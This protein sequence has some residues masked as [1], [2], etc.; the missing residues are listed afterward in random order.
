MER[1]VNAAL[2]LHRNT[3]DTHVNNYHK[4][5]N[6]PQ[7]HR[8]IDKSNTRKITLNLIVNIKKMT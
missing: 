1:Q 5:N 6:L 7:T 3:T 2:K 4:Y 8:N